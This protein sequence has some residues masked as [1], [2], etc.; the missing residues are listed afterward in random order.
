MG[1]ASK[2][3]QANQLAGAAGLMSNKPPG[4]SYGAQGGYGVAQ[5]Q[6]QSQGQGQ[7]YGQGAYGSP[8][9]APPQ[10]QGQYGQQPGQ[11]GAQ[12]GQYGQQ[13][14]GQ[15]GQS[16]SQYGQT[17]GQY[18]QYG[19]TPGQYGQ[20]P[21]APGQGPGQGQYGQQQQ[22]GY[23][24]PPV[25]GGRPGQPAYGSQQPGQFPYGQ[26]QPGQYGQQQPGQYGQQQP[27]QY[28]QQ[29]GAPGAY[30]QQQQYGAPGGYGQAG[31][32]PGGGGVN[33]QYVAQT[34]SQCVRDQ[35]LE[36]FYPPQALDPIAQ[37]VVQSGA[38]QQLAANWKLPVELATDLVK[39]AL[40]DVVVLID[41][42]GSM[43]FEQNGERIE[44]LKMILGKIAFACSLFDHDGIQV[45]FLNSQLQGNN[46]NSD[47]AALQLVQQV[48][49]SGLTP[50]G[51][52]LDQKILQPLLLG[53][54]RS[55]A[56]QKPLLIIAITDGAPAG[57]STD[58]IVQV[59]TNANHELQRSRYGPDA[60]S[61]Q[62]SQVGNDKSAQKFLSSLD[63]NPTIGSLI[64]QTMDYE[65][66]QEQMKQK[67]GEDL[68]PEMWLMKLLLGPIDTSYDSKD[69]TNAPPRRY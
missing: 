9:G 6:S 60:V 28:G 17:P 5:S 53:P 51:T 54:A 14:Q 36:A 35:H 15:Y 58:K 20:H 25:P 41:D 43:A 7:G 56:L 8:Y 69:E 12:Q 65:Y 30:G 1:F 3:A 67:T 24:A 45:R 44:D 27:G 2:I 63:D 4:A 10:G 49:F 61:Y 31:G 22:Q 50:L 39:I 33:A 52:A 21:G 48:K 34:L 18:G 37:R 23:G 68:S 26:Q 16:G 47:Q 42:S 19:Q 13:P 46:I 59:I 55:N 29:P 62:L 64:D 66:E 57:E 11:Y 40:F 32:A 38:L